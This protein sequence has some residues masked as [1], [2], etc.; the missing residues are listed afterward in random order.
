MLIE[1]SADIKNFMLSFIIY[2][3]LFKNPSDVIPFMYYY[4]I[5]ASVLTILF[6]MRLL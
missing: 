2:N 1:T 3:R 4:L 5:P 6:I